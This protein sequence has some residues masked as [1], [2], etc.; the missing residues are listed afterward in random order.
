MKKSSRNKWIHITDNDTQL[1]DVK[2]A[3][4]VL[5]LDLYLQGPYNL[6]FDTNFAIEN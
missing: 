6:S 4:L 5:L 2:F 3:R 1:H